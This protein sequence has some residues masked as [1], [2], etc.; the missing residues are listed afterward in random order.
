MPDGAVSAA[1]VRRAQRTGPPVAGPDATEPRV[2]RS[3]TD[4]TATMRATIAALMAR[5]KREVP[6][7]YLSDQVDLGPA[8]SWLNQRNLA[9]PVP[10]RL[11]PAVM[12]LKAAARAAREVSE[13]NGYWIDDGF[14]ARDAV[15][16]GIAVSLRGGGLV[17]PG[18]RDADALDLPALMAAMRDLVARTRSGRLRSSEL[19]DPTITISSLGDQGVEA[20]FG[21]IYP[22]QVALVGFGRI[23]E[24]PWAID[25]LIGIRPVVTVSLSG[26]HRATDGATGARYLRSVARLLQRPEEL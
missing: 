24:R 2:G 23:V 18:I 13:L 6:H 12:L 16:L 19:A 25:G 1:D 21:I 15:H 14:V 20:I 5:S 7:Y 22:P 9:L 17:A 26:D 8:M 3:A 11:V 10:Q 4:T